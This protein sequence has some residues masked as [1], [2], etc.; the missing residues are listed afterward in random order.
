MRAHH[1]NVRPGEDR[2]AYFQGMTEEELHEWSRQRLMRIEAGDL[3]AGAAPQ[4]TTSKRFVSRP[5]RGTVARQAHS[6]THTGGSKEPMG[7]NPSKLNLDQVKLLRYISEQESIDF[8]KPGRASPQMAEAIGVKT[9]NVSS[10]LRT[11]ESGG[12]LEVERTTGGYPR[13]VSITETG[14]KLVRNPYVGMH[15]RDAV[16]AYLGDN[17]PVFGEPGGGAGR[18]RGG[19][20]A[21]LGG[22]KGEWSP[23]LSHYTNVSSAL[24]ELHKGGEIEAELEHGRYIVGAWL[25]G[26]PPEKIA[27]ARRRADFPVEAFL[28][29]TREAEAAEKPSEEEELEALA[30]DFDIPEVPEVP[31]PVATEGADVHALADALLERVIARAL[32]TDGETKAA[33]IFKTRCKELAEELEAATKLFEEEAKKSESLRK[34]LVEVRGSLNSRIAESNALR[35]RLQETIDKLARKNGSTGGGLRQGI[36]QE[37]LVKLQK[38]MQETPGASR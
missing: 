29:H 15:T 31:E 27:E 18:G 33:E 3:A 26:T 11:F 23:I 22:K 21:V 25:P 4:I 20:A 37:D 8:K 13:R 9:G 7:T 34:E 5:S 30:K 19:V 36:K 12:W 6:G 10:W 35:E 1:S 28:K 2:L 32:A 14:R 24:Q 38:F 17:G 16:R